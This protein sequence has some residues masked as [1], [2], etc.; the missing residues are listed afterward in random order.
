MPKPVKTKTCSLWKM[1]MVVAT[2][3]FG[4]GI[5]KPDV[6]LSSIT[7]QEYQSYYRKRAVEGATR[8]SHCL[9][10]TVTRTSKSAP[11][12]MSESLWPTGDWHALLQDV[13]AMPKLPFQ[14]GNSSCII[15]GKN[16]TMKRAKVATWTITCGT[17]KEEGGRDGSGYPLESDQ[18]NNQQCKGQG[19]VHVMMVGK[20]NALIRRTAPTRNRFWHW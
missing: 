20:I 2:I 11:K 3:A 19:M 17:Q 4:M 7:C 12:F 1:P 18:R 16:L 13:V 14:G 5:D 15:L 10:F 6:D 9:A 8:R